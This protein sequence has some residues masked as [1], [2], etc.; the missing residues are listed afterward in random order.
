MADPEATSAILAVGKLIA[1]CAKIAACG[2]ESQFTFETDG[3]EVDPWRW[4]Y[5]SQR[6]QPMVYA[7]WTTLPLGAQ[8]QGKPKRFLSTTSV[9]HLLQRRYLPVPGD[10]KASPVA[11]LEQYWNPGASSA[12]HLS[13]LDPSLLRI[14][15]PENYVCCPPNELQ[16]W[17]RRRGLG[18]LVGGNPRGGIAASG[19][20]LNGPDRHCLLYTSDAADE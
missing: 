7:L 12:E 20:K 6:S 18:F 14:V 13:G 9:N 8:W 5:T 2:W 16:A 1:S 10:L 3:F 4:A 19:A 11:P 17:M 15:S